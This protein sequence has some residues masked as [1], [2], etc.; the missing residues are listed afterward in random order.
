MC[1][2]RRFHQPVGGKAWRAGFVQNPRWG[3][4][5]RNSRLQLGFMLT[6]RSSKMSP[7]F[8]T[9]SE[10]TFSATPLNTPQLLIVMVSI[11]DLPRHIRCDNKEPNEKHSRR[12]VQV[13]W[14][15]DFG[16]H[17]AAHFHIELRAGLENGNNW[18]LAKHRAH[19][20]LLLPLPSGGKRLQ[21]HHS[22]QKSTEFTTEFDW[23]CS[24]GWRYYLWSGFKMALT[25]WRCSLL[26]IRLKKRSPSVLR[27]D[28]DAPQSA[29]NV[30]RF[31]SNQA[32]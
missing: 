13:P 5:C 32:H 1:W 2:S 31:W 20:M 6:E 23:G 12:A 3:L 15:T 10:E 9:C 27:K 24:C 30:V 25:R 16:R 7:S 18:S 8:L 26:K 14:R 28:L 17:K 4:L 11:R 21:Y 19:R 29:K 22:R